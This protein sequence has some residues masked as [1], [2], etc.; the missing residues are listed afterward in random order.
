MIDRV[1][2][3]RNNPQTGKKETIA[4]DAVFEESHEASLEVTDT[5]WK[6]ALWFLTM[7][8]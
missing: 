3:F 2:I 7:R 1:A 5:P 6:L 8:L 4:F